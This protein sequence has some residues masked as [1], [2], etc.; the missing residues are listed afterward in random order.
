MM[1]QNK[2]Q[3]S[4]RDMQEVL[5]TANKMEVSEQEA[6]ESITRL[7]SLIKLLDQMYEEQ[8]GEVCL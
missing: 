4:T 8:N 3:S 7:V 5:R 1:L 2:I 6:A